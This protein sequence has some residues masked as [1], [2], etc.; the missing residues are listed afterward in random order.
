MF[1]LD[2]EPSMLGFQPLQLISP[3]VEFRNH[4]ADMS[5]EKNPIELKF[6]WIDT[7]SR[8]GMLMLDIT[9]HNKLSRVCHWNMTIAR[10]P[11]V[12][13]VDAI[14]GVDLAT[15]VDQS[16]VTSLFSDHLRCL[17]FDC[18]RELAL[19]ECFLMLPILWVGHAARIHWSNSITWD[20]MLS[21]MLLMRSWISCL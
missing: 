12:V 4:L 13:G 19:C 7:I 2:F 11:A 16:R 1:L 8:Y 3:S 20:A 21:W 14:V 17:N 6:V 9:E 15:S 5:T 10:C 18:G